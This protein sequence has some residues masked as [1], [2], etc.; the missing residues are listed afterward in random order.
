[1]NAMVD[2]I[3]AQLGQVD[4][5]RQQRRDDPSLGAR[6]AA[7]KAYQAARFAST[8]ADLLASPRYGPAARFFLDELYGP[9]AFDQRDAQF[10][11]VL[12]VMMRAIP[13]DLAQALGTLAELHALTESL[14]SEMA[15]HLPPQ[16][17]PGAA[18]P[19]ALG[20]DAYAAAWRDCG[21]RDARQ[22]QVRL[23]MD[24]GR[25]LDRH[26]RN[27]LLRGALRMM[28]D[29][30][31]RAGYSELQRFL[32]QGFNAFGGMQGSAEFLATV[33]QREQALIDALFKADP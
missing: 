9:Q 21:R 32:E 10:A 18:P 28:R 17:A 25:A 19:R 24:L 6:V 33:Q 5:L 8:Y 26:T 2:Q 22:M 16:P 1:M 11:H 30:A 27:P 7:V 15:L 12:P 14:D 31:R 4:A 23:T 13:K 29:P 20:A 3:R